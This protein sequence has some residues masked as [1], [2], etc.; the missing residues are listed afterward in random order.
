MGLGS[1]GA[2]AGTEDDGRGGD[3][4][5]EEGGTE[6][7]V[8]LGDDEDDE[9]V[10]EGDEDGDED[11]VEEEEEEGRG[12]GRGA[13]D[14]E[15]DERNRRKEGI[16]MVV[17]GVVLGVAPVDGRRVVGR[18]REKRKVEGK[19]ENT[20][21][22]W[23]SCGRSDRRIQGSARRPAVNIVLLMHYCRKNLSSTKK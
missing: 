19:G 14:D 6:S 22:N 4:E 16:I 9:D 1:A 10:D 12:E 5:G 17:A 11:G 13:E 3:E 18:P 20:G 21:D 15:E 23:L 2:S 7:D 8:G